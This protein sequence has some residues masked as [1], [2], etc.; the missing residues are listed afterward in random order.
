MKLRYPAEAF[1]L[2]II[3]FSAS[4][5]EAFTAGILVIFSAV[6]AEFLKNLLN[7]TIPAWSVKLCVA[8]ATGTLCSSAFLIGF[9]YLGNELSTEAWSITFLVGLL[10]S[11][12]TLSD[13]VNAEYGELLYES[14]L[15]WGFWIL[16]AIIREFM[17]NGM[18]FG[19]LS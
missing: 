5:K 2:G 12:H 17:G 16:L 4:M 15:V 1:A 6:F 18:I 9:S 3:L 19:N 13:R 8:I 14:A 7:E 10:C 11:Y